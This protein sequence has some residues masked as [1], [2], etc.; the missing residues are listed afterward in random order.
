VIV[1]YYKRYIE[2]KSIFLKAAYGIEI[3]VL[4]KEVMAEYLNKGGK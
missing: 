1:A 3:F 4:P 2:I